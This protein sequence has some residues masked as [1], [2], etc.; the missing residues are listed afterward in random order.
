MERE[1]HLTVEW[2]AFDLRPGIPQEGTPRTD[3]PGENKIGRPVDGALGET[4]REAGLVMNRA[5]LV[6][7]TRP[8]MEAGE[9][10]KSQ[11]RFDQFH[12]AA[13]KAYWEEGENLGDLGVL[14]RVAERVS[15][16]PEGLAR[17]LRDHQ[18]TGVVEE[19]VEFARKI[20]I[21]GIPA[22]IVDRYLVV[23]AQ[24]YDF[25]KMVVDRVLQERETDKG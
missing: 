17:A 4:A 8:A 7:F 11:E 5:G 3:R 23:G 20:G 24:P 18:Y 6:P 1:Y 21:S 25:F 12:K 2:K 16:D 15:L 22:F 14:Q 9:Y 13:F 10:A 19:Q